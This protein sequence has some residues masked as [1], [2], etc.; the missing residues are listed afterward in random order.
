MTTA[1]YTSEFLQWAYECFTREQQQ[2]KTRLWPEFLAEAAKRAMKIMH[3]TLVAISLVSHNNIGHR[4]S[5]TGVIDRGFLRWLKYYNPDIQFCL[6]DL[7]YEESFNR[8]LVMENHTY[9]SVT[10][11]VS[12]GLPDCLAC[13]M[14]EYWPVNNDCIV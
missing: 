7:H 1:L 6:G 2:G 3:P 13:W 12:K 14:E 5:Y 10:S 9:I 4:Y 11:F 8:L